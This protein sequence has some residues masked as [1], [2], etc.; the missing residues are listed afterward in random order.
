MSKYI[1][2]ISIIQDAFEDR[3]E[4]RPRQK[5]LAKMLKVS[6]QTVSNWYHSES[7]PGIDTLMKLSEISALSINEFII[8]KV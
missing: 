3:M 4:V 1:I 5:D 2:D 8:K 6:E 7:S